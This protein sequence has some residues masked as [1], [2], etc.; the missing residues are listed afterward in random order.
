MITVIDS[1]VSNLGSMQNMLKRLSI[2]FKVAGTP[3][4]I[5]DAAS[6]ILPG[7]GAF[8]AGMRNLHARGL[9]DILTHKALV[10]K[11]PVMGVCLGMQLMTQ[12][13]E[14]G[15]QPGLGWVPAKAIRFQPTTSEQRVP[16]MGWNEV[17]PTKLDAMTTHMR[18]DTRF[19]FVHS[20]HVV[21]DDPSDILLTAPFGATP[22]TAAYRRGNL[23]G[24]QFHPEK[25]HKFGMWL[26]RNF[27]EMTA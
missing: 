6:I 20:Y 24:M 17:T 19:Y 27:S 1:G 22:Y 26:L 3:Q 11:V 12:G 4:D 9:V 14:E 23:V 18:P 7:V 2:P 8:D 16:F 5:E 13:S 21:C 15:Q 10:E 25:S